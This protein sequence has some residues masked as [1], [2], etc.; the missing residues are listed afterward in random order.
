MRWRISLLAIFLLGCFLGYELAAARQEPYF[1][2]NDINHFFF[3]N[4]VSEA[5]LHSVVSGDWETVCSPM[6][7]GLDPSKKIF[8]IFVDEGIFDY[9][10][11]IVVLRSNGEWGLMNFDESLYTVSSAADC[12]P[13]RNAVIKRT[14]APSIDDD[15]NGLPS[16]MTTYELRQTPP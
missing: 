12:M 15:P 7:W 8:G 9:L 14:V 11:K 13:F 4:S 1:E 3:R 6:P 10:F 2:S 16:A 5:P